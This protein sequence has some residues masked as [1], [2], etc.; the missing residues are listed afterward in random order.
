MKI[1]R[2]TYR[3]IGIIF[4]TLFCYSINLAGI[5]LS[6][7]GANIQKWRRFG[8]GLWGR[9]MCRI[10]GVR[11][12][13]VGKPPAAP[14]YLVS[15]HLGYVDI[16]IITAVAKSVFVAKNE[17]KKW[18]IFGFLMSTIGMI[19]IDRAKM[20]D[21]K[22]VN[23]EIS[24]RLNKGYGITIFPEATTSPGY[25]L[26]PFKSS[27]L[28]YPA[29]FEIPVY[30]ASLTYSVADSKIEAYNSVV[31]WGDISFLKHFFQLLSIKR[32]HGAIRFNEEPIVDKNRKKLA[33]SLRQ[34]V[35]NIFEPVVSEKEFIDNHKN[36]YTPKF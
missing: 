8:L 32:I 6:I 23:A 36:E 10:F 19:F 11:I 34:S 2:I 17:M 3:L 35:L 18:P 7:F 5:I 26:L 13:V 4:I 15:N 27:L 20:A 25:G 21:V 30:S 28:A 31:W 1:I 9:G 16:F 24:D 33:N 29:E 22:R 14:F 12:N